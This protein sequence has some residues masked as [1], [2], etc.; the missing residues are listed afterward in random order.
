MTMKSGLFFLTARAVVFLLLSTAVHAQVSFLHPPTVGLPGSA[1]V[2]DFNGD[3][4]PDMLGTDG[5]LELGNG[6]GTFTLGTA[7]SGGALAV[8]DF[9]GDGKTDVLQQGTGTLLVL[10]GNGD[11]TFKTAISTPSGASL[12]P[13]A[14]VDLN[15]D[16]KADVVGIFNGALIVYL[17]KGDGTFLSGVSYNIGASAGG[18]VLSFGDFNGD[19]KTDVVVSVSS[20]AAG[21]EIVFLGNGDGTLQAAKSSP[22]ILSPTYTV[23]GDFNGDGKLDLVI[24]GIPSCSGTCPPPTAYFLAGRGDGTFDAATSI[25]SVTG[26]YAAIPLAA[27]DVN[28][29]GKLDLICEAPPSV[30]QVYLGNGDG[31]FTN[32]GNYI[33]TYYLNGNAPVI[34]DFNGD[35]K[36]DV[37]MGYVVLLGNGD[38]TFQGIRLGVASNSGIQIA[39]RFDKTSPSPGVAVLSNQPS[40]VSILRNDGRGVLSLAHTYALQAPGYGVATADLNGDGNLDLFVAS[41]DP[42]T[43]MWGYSV[44]LGNGD[45]SFQSPIFVQE[46]IQ[47]GSLS[48]SIVVADFNGDHNMDIALCPGAGSSAQSLALLLGKGDGTF[49]APTYL[50]DAGGCPLAAADFNGDGKIDIAASGSAG[51]ELLLGN[52]DG[53]F[54]AAIIPP[55]LQQ[56]GF[57]FTA[58]VNNDGNADLVGRS[59]IALGNGDGTFTVLPALPYDAIQIGDLNGDGKLDLFVV[60]YPPGPVQIHNF[61]TGIALGNGDGTFGPFIA[62]YVPIDWD[63]E[64]IIPKVSI[65]DMNGDGRPDMFFPWQSGSG[66]GVMLNTT[67]PG[68]ALT[69]S[70]LSPAAVTAGGSGTSTVSVT[71]TF[72]FAGAGTVTLSCAGLPSGATCQFSPTSMPLGSS[73]SAL[74]ITASTS[75]ATGTYSVQIEGIAGSLT[76]STALSLIVQTP[77]DFAI[78]ASPATQTISAGQ[79]ANFNVVGTS[80]G[81]LAAT[82]NL[83]CAITPVVTSAPT[84]TLSPSALPISPNGT[85]SA[86]VTVATTAPMT[87]ITAPRI[88][89]PVAKI[90]LMWSMLCLGL[91]WNRKRRLARIA[92]LIGLALASLAGCG[93][94]NSSHTIPGTPSGTY[95]VTIT[96]TTGGQT[97]SAVMQVVVQ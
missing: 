13:V 50:F 84:C 22:G 31:T 58:D 90:P 82:V 83:T 21:Q 97:H 33:L 64:P 36:L 79:T 1:F 37:A 8:G 59:T 69:A 51:T 34:A 17:S 80:M 73:S 72:G 48:Y 32:G 44:L 24:S 95:T 60:Q 89:L 27:A 30:G 42:S 10:L 9:N 63:G 26:G 2:A 29:D 28:G 43:Q 16:G 71:P 14:A 23:V 91:L 92:L 55:G 94:G 74:V 12:G 40:S 18:A 68:F 70:R 78:M 35:G 87:V 3:G 53:T 4:K 47:T 66:V 25:S 81:S 5:T 67:P 7:V 61:Q 45:G 11:G 65:A 77:P 15:G 46:N 56:I 93:G 57:E 88:D 86:A 62:V 54:Q 41:T 75:T 52:G 76:S 96:G 6:D 38:G 85:Q 39:G 49:A 20:N 19:S